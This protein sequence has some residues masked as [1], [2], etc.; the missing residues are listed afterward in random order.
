[1]QVLSQL[2]PNTFS[3]NGKVEIKFDLTAANGNNIPGADAL[4]EIKFNGVLYASVHNPVPGSVP[5]TITY[6]NGATGTPSSL[7]QQSTASIS[8]IVPDPGTAAL[9]EFAHTS[10]LD[11]WYLDNVSINQCR[12]TDGDGIPDF[13]DT[14]S[15]NDGCPDATEA[16]NNI[17]TTATLA[18][19]SNGGSNGNLGTTVNA[20]GIPIP[21]GTVGGSTGQATTANVTTALQI[22]IGTQPASQSVLTG[23]P[24]TFTVAATGTSTATFAAG[25]PNYTVPPGTNVTSTLTY[26][27]QENG[28]NLTNTGVYADVTTATLNISNVTGLNGKV[29]TVVIKHPNREC[30]ITSNGATLTTIDR[31]DPVASG[32]LDSDGDGVTNVCDLDDDN[33]GILDTVEAPLLSC[34]LN[35]P[36]T[37]SA[38]MAFGAGRPVSNTHDNNLNT[39]GGTLLGVGTLDG[40]V[41]Y[42][43][44]TPIN[45]VTDF[46]IYSNGGSV[47][48]D[49]QLNF[50]SSIK[51]YNSANVLIYQQ[52]N[53]NIPSASVTFP[54]I[55]TFPTPLQDVKYF[56][57]TDLKDTSNR[58]V[59]WK[60]VYLRSCA[61]PR[62]TDGDGIPDY[63]DLD[64]DNDGCS[65][66]IEGGALIIEN[67]LVTAGGTLQ[68]GNGVNPATPP[69]SGTF[70]QAVLQNLGTTNVNTN[71][72]PQFTS[73]PTGYS[74][75]T[76][77][78]I[79]SS[80]NA[81]IN[82]CICYN[83]PN[84]ATAGVDTKHGIT[85]LQ[86]AGA[87]NGNW[88]MIRKSA[89]TVLESNTK[90]FVI[91][92]MSTANL[93]NI[94][95]PQDGM[96]VYDTTVGCL[97]IYTT[98]AAM[99]ANTGWKCFIT[100][101]CPQ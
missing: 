91:T 71:G 100:P 49:G 76:G 66:A 77:Q 34:V 82:G 81:A 101:T 23:S 3:S 72:I 79:G 95:T 74:N 21:P 55:I 36:N 6:S 26:Q 61:P 90:G 52:N 99:A 54:F 11:D 58:E 22:A 30:S 88:P 50:I 92:R 69:T 87:D 75:S 44:T 1:N 67:Q 89:H 45:N 73:L 70:N 9:L 39:F 65:D 94:T 56:T 80:I 8:I 5:V 51:Y 83:D 98:D 85:L 46:R 41:T 32:L 27:W 40:T 19:G 28:V 47:L 4:L 37:S 24:A 62:D 15:D 86:R 29:Y 48:N 93:V 12:D 13:L 64:S 68:G 17:V 35:S 53:V 31:C 57:F 14:D 20:N 60:D 63:L 25:T 18:G 97:K 43:Y 10:G 38:T 84:I 59:I 42:N 96:M 16:A 33:D 2:I 78:T 7:A